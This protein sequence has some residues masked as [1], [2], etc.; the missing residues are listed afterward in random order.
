MIVLDA[1]IQSLTR[2]TSISRRRG[3]KQ[4]PARPHSTFAQHRRYLQQASWV[5]GSLHFGLGAPDASGDEVWG[6]ALTPRSTP[7]AAVESGLR[8]AKQ[9]A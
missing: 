7:V 6:L 1:V 3:A 8:L 9:A 5:L 2:A 4:V